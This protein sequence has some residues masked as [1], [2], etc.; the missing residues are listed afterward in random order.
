MYT[1]ILSIFLLYT[2]TSVHA[3]DNGLALTPPLGWMSWQRF[4]CI[5]DCVN[6]PNDCISDQLFRDTADRMAEDGYLE[7]GYE[8]L[9][10]DDCWLANERDSD[11]R[12]QPNA[13]R[14][15]NGIKDLADYIH[16]K[17]LKFG[18]YE[19]IGTNTCAGYPGI[20]GQ[21]EIDANTFAEW[22]V[23][24]I[25]VDGCYED[26]E[27]ME[28]KYAQFGAYLNQTERPIV[29]SCSFPAYKGLEA[30]YTAAVEICNLWRNYGDIQ[31]QWDDVK[32]IANWFATNQGFL[33][34]FAGPG[35]WNDPDMLIIGDYGLSYDESIA[36]MTIWTVM[37]APLLMSVD[38]RKIEP[39]FRDILLNS[40]ALSINQD[41]LGIP[42]LLAWNNGN[43]RIWTKPI[44]P[45]VDDKNSYAFGIV[46]YENGGSPHVVEF[47]LDEFGLDNADGYTIKNVF[48]PS[49]PVTVSVTEPIRISVNPSGAALLQVN[50]VAPSHAT[51][52]L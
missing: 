22:G 35:H 6:Y 45:Q 15:P 26:T 52:L 12:L 18:I 19:D 11:G 17:G 40:D 5:T 30:N 7:A 42:G 38:L 23:D 36:Q 50:P 4:R 48:E 16:S 34:K 41:A 2:F 10:I 13:D 21:Y 47:T 49:D 46:N 43:V 31:D 29:Y 9:I 32:N 1:K 3:L 28:D 37:A 25:K 27:G 8:Y 51:S 39:E 20:N 33:N 14:F 24:Y 44:L